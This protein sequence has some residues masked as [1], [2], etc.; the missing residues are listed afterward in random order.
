MRHGYRFLT[1]AVGTLPPTMR[2]TPGLACLIAVASRADLFA[3]LPISTRLAAVALA[4]VATGA[5]GKHR[6]ATLLSALPGPQAFDVI[7]E[8]PYPTNIHGFRDDWTMI[9][10][11]GAG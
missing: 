11:C 7:V 5:D 1:L 3:T 9:R 10:A 6:P 4:S 2:L 8:L